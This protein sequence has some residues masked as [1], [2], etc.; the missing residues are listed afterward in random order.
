M[1]KFYKVCIR[2]RSDDVTDKIEFHTWTPKEYNNYIQSIREDCEK[3]FYHYTVSRDN[4][5]IFINIEH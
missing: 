5:K 2:H 1:L 3:H 4:N